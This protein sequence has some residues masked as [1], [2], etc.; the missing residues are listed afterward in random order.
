MFRGVKSSIKFSIRPHFNKASFHSDHVSAISDPNHL[1]KNSSIPKFVRFHI[2]PFPQ[3]VCAS[4]GGGGEAR[5]AATKSS[6]LTRGGPGL[7]KMSYLCRIYLKYMSETGKNSF[8]F[9]KTKINGLML[10]Y[11]PI[12]PNAKTFAC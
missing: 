6:N 10:L 4:R 1:I 8:L 5:F 11:E 9:I 2:S 7:T 3:N 12:T